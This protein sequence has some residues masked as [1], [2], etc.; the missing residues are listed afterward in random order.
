M[1]ES[2]EL[3]SFNANSTK[4]KEKITLLLTEKIIQLL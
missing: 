2:T 1:T 3:L 4:H